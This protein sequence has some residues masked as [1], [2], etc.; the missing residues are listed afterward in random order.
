[1]KIK[2]KSHPKKEGKTPKANH[3]TP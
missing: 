1:M 3:S 2:G